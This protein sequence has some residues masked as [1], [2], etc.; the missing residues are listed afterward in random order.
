MFNSFESNPE[1][2]CVSDY[3]PQ[4]QIDK[5]KHFLYTHIKNVCK[6][7]NRNLATC[8]SNNCFLKS[9]TGFSS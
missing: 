3:D 2:C 1:S 9:V 6:R 5:Y 8:K 7:Q 4:R